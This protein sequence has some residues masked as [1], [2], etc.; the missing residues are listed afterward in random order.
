LW[1]I[2]KKMYVK[3]NKRVVRVRGG[4]RNPNFRENPAIKGTSGLGHNLKTK[5]SGGNSFVEESRCE[6][7]GEQ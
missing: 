5:K 1:C 7:Q 6:T 2:Q 3:E 4:L